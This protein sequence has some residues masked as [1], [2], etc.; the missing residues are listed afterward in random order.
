MSA[1]RFTIIE[2][3][4][5]IIIFLLIVLVV[6]PFALGFKIKEDYSVLVKDLANMMQVDM[7][8]MQ[9]DRGFFSSDVL[10]EM[11]SPGMPFSLQFKENIVHGPIYLGMLNQEKS[12]FIAAYVSGELL[13]PTGYEATFNKAFNNKSGLVYQNIIDFEGNVD[14][15]GYMPAVS[16]E[17][18]QETGIT[19]IKSSGMT[20]TSRFN[21][22]KGQLS[23]DGKLSWFKLMSPD[24]IVNLDKV[25]LSYSGVMGQNNLL[26]GDSVASFDKLEIQSTDQFAMQ[27]FSINTRTTE[28]G[29][30]VNSEMRMNVRE[31]FASNQRIGPVVFN[32]N[33]NGLNSKALTQIQ[34]IQAEMENK[35]KQGIP[36][37]QINAMLAGQMIGIVPELIKQAVITIDPLSLES[38]LG[39]LEASLDFS[40]EGIDENAPADPLFLLT[41]LKLDMDFNVDEPLLRQLIEWQLVA[42]KAKLS[43]SMNDKA[44]SIEA[45]IPMEQ[46]VTE[47]LKG[48]VDENWLVLK[49]KKYSSHISLNKGE[50]LL[51]GTA[52]NPLEQF[53]PQMTAPSPTPASGGESPYQ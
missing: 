39:K 2:F 30:L 9:Y 48:L 22:S 47:N 21:A 14:S 42:N 8:I 25:D 43:A 27:K 51:N 4:I 5:W 31:I 11:Q 52:V 34:E 15:V 20:L 3:S 37:E 16:T 36:P 49:D 6:S 50:M 53:M 40:V 41:A 18:E 7:R 17:I 44:Q 32:I 10:I 46:K 24:A 1:K 23:G 28:S 13:A 12:P 29:V 38:E 35:V 19:T 45:G 26:M 33:V